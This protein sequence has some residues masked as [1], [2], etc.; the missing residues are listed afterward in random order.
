MK[1]MYQAR[2]ERLTLENKIRELIDEFESE[3]DCIVNTISVKHDKDD[4]I[5]D[6]V[7]VKTD[8]G[9]HGENIDKNQTLLQNMDASDIGKRIIPNDCSGLG[10]PI[11]MDL[12]TGEIVEGD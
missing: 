6:D 3:T 7:T 2:H 10:R 9:R 4:G 1:D 8:I 11:A 5:I 12:E